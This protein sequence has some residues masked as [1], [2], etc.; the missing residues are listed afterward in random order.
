MKLISLVCISFLMGICLMQGQP[1]FEQKILSEVNPHWAH[2]PLTDEQSM[3]VRQCNSYTDKIQL[4]LELVTG[5][6]IDRTAN[7]DIDE[8]T[9]QKRLASLDS[10]TDYHKRSIFPLN[11][12]APFPTPVFVDDLGTHCAVGYMLHTSGYDDV[13][14]QIATEDNLSY[15]D[16]LD[17]KYP[18]LGDWAC[19]NGFTVEELAWI[20]PVYEYHCNPQITIGEIIHNTCYGEC[21][22]AFFADPASIIGIPPGVV[23]LWG[24]TFRWSNGK[25]VDIGIPDCLCN[26][27]YRQEFEAYSIEDDSSFSVFVEA[28][29]VSP[30]P[31]YVYEEVTG[32]AGLC[33][34]HIE[35]YADGGVPPYTFEVYDMEGN[36]YGLGPLCQGYY[37][38]VTEDANGCSDSEMLQVYTLESD[39]LAFSVTDMQL[40]NP[41]PGYLNVTLFLE[42]DSSTFINFPFYADVE[43]VE[44]NQLAWGVNSFNQFGGTSQTYLFQTSLSSLPINAA[45]TFQMDFLKAFCQLPYLSINTSTLK[46]QELAMSLYPNPMHTETTILFNEVLTNVRLQI[47]NTHSQ[48]VKAWTESGKEAIT[49]H[50]EN[51]PPGLYTIQVVA[52]DKTGLDRFVIVD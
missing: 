23:F 46:S 25:W 15:V 28:E 51:L 1:S 43:D 24:S 35:P 26:G 10:L 39:C 29:I 40:N 4:H 48:L 50:R 17:N 38:L 44:G 16:D 19:E 6:L 5:I 2:V 7:M 12:K 36:T 34:A 27:L 22:G 49:I 11:N 18:V 9:R 13:V 3:L 47:F 14:S 52:G 21:T 33:R 20:Q 32:E 30:E 42:G 45:L 37:Y 31:L 8:S 41:N